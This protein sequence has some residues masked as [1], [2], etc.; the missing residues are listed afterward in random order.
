MQVIQLM[1]GREARAEMLERV[2][3]HLMP[4]GVLAAAL[5]DPFEGEP[6][7]EAG[8]PLPDVREQD[9]WVF[10]S[11][12]VAVR[13]EGDRTA[14]DRVRQAVSPSGRLDESMATIV[15][16]RRAGGGGGGS[17]FPAGAPPPR[18]AER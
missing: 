12:P 13:S 8:P 3:G 2:R 4:G 11:M 10:S 15:L 7:E 18:A 17:G 1:G 16:D 5:A 9:G 6:P 14:I